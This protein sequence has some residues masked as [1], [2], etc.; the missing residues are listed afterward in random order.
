MPEFKANYGT[1]TP[2]WKLDHITKYASSRSAQRLANETNL[3]RQFVYQYCSQN[4]LKLQKRQYGEGEPCYKDIRRYFSKQESKP[5]VRPKA[6]YDNPSWQE[7]IN[8]LLSEG[9][10]HD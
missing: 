5:I 10:G 3:S 7:R 4:G 6:V 2:Q 8:Q 1:F 9:T